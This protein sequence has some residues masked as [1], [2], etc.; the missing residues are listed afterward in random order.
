MPSRGELSLSWSTGE[1]FLPTCLGNTLPSSHLQSAGRANSG[2]PHATSATEKH[3]RGANTNNAFR[4]EYRNN[5]CRAFLLALQTPVA[6][7]KEFRLRHGSWWPD[8][9][10]FWLQKTEQTTDGNYNSAFS[11][12]FNKCSSGQK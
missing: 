1:T 10:A 11:H 7:G 8:E 5:H 12:H 6:E 9:L 3:P 2:T 4:K